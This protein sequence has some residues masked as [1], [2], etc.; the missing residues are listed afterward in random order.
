MSLI[1]SPA[2]KQE[3][4]WEFKGVGGKK[5]QN[6]GRGAMKKVNKGRGEWKRERERERDWKVILYVAH[7]S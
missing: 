6:K 3:G 7:R 4:D 5:E 2:E 1:P